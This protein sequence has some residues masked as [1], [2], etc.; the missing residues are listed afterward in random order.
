MSDREIEIPKGCRVHMPNPESGLAN[1]ICNKSGDIL[2]RN[3]PILR[4]VT[5]IEKSQRRDRFFQNVLLAVI[6]GAVMASLCIWIWRDT[7]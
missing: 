7:I 2:Y 5:I 3:V 6:W 4:L 1:V